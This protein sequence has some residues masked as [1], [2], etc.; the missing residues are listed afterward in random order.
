MRSGSEASCRGGGSRSPPA[1]GSDG[2]AVGPRGL[3]RGRRRSTMSGWRAER[4]RGAL[5][6]K[7]CAVSSTGCRGRRDR[8]SAWGEQ[9]SLERRN[10]GENH[11]CDRSCSRVAWIASRSP[12]FRCSSP[13]ISPFGVGVAI[14][15]GTGL[16]PAS[17]PSHPRRASCSRRRPIVL[18]SASRRREE[19]R[20]ESDLLRCGPPARERRRALPECPASRTRGAVSTRARR[21]HPVAPDRS[22]AMGSA[23]VPSG[24]VT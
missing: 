10:L 11:S 17:S 3:C 7:G 23:P 19:E 14:N 24:K 15:V 1:I 13:P 9:P 12:R 18:T 20:A 8:A 5:L 21:N 16:H 2:R 22:P 6:K 4:F